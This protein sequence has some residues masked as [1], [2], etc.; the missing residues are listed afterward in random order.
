MSLTTKLARER[1]TR[2]PFGKSA[3]IPHTDVERAIKGVED[4]LSAALDAHLADTV[5]AHDASAISVSPT[6]SLAATDVQA[7]L[8]EILGDIEAHVADTVGAH[9]ATAISFTPAG[10]IAAITVQ[11]AIEELDTEKQP[12]DATL[13]A[14]AGLTVAQGDLIYGT[15]SDAFAMLNKD[16]NA[17]R[18]LSNTGTLNN[19]AWAQVNLANGVTGDL[20]FA[21][22]TQIAGLSVL[23]VTGNST[24]D[25]A[26]IAA[27]NDHEVL[28][29]SGTALAFG[30][31]ATDGLAAD[32]VTFAKMQ[33]IT[34]DRLIGR[35]TASSGDPEEISLDS[36][37]EFTGSASIRR[38]A[39]T[40]AIAASAGSNTTTSAVDL[41]VVIGDGTNAITTGVKGYFPIDFACTITQWTLVADASGSIV[42]DVWKDTY[43]NFPPTDADSIAGSELPTLSS[44]QKNQDTSLSTWTTSVSAGD[45]LGFNVDSATT[46]KQVTLTLKVTKTS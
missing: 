44:Q 15:G 35:D 21:N 36:T 45:V 46:V 22:L 39:L 33:N 34:S 16:A 3:E 25:V 20:P 38:A 5:D 32:A 42:I 19:P 43:A 24:A 18:Y 29:R 30:T 6:G 28:R 1:A 23:G 41:V 12:I 7:A 26:G 8:V 11:A 17:T 4:T 13:T 9:A 31:V 10:A 40:G 14:L 2:V 37:L 27:G